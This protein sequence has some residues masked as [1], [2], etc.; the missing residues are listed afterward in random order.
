MTDGENTYQTFVHI[1]TG[2]A[3][4]RRRM[5]AEVLALMITKDAESVLTRDE[6]R[7]AMNEALRYD[8]ITLNVDGT[9]DLTEAGRLCVD[10]LSVARH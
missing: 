8:W 7:M 5:A 10:C 3:A 6:I 2:A 9:F 1:A 4:E